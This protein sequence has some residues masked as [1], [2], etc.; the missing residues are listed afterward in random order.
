[1]R[2]EFTLWTALLSYVAPALGGNLLVGYYPTWKHGNI[3]TM[4]L[5]NYT[6]INIAFAIPNE[7][8]ALKF[9]GDAFM[10]K[11]VPKLQGGGSKVL[12]SVGGW[13]G[14]ANFSTIVKD[15]ALSGTLTKN[16]IDMMKKYKLDG[17]DID[18]EF[19]GRKGS[20]C[21]TVDEQ[22]DATNFLKY[23][24]DLRAKMDEALGKGKLITLALR[25]QPFDGPGGKDVSGFAKVVDFANLMQY[26]LNGAWGETSG[27]LAPLNFEKG[28]GTQQ[29]FATA[30]EEWTKAGWP[31]KQ[32]TGGAAFYGYSATAT[33]DM[34]KSNPPSQYAKMAKE[35]PKGDQDD[36]MVTEPCSSAA[37]TYTGIWVYK[38]LRKQGVLSSPDTAE[39][40]WVRTFDNK[41]MT[42][43]LFNPQTKTFISYDDPQSLAAKVKFAESKGL[44]GMMVWSIER[45]Y[46]GELLS[47][48][49]KFSSK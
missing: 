34:L 45:D 1:M 32:L 11:V 24:T 49:K 17:I 19:P 23:L 41:T 48:L 46:N 20:D 40:P 33:E 6:H 36:E 18:W 37:A 15:T 38:N 3:S 26:D 10:D 44:G 7:Q 8:G 12:V 5:S 27:P 9:E 21:N 16:I 22:N 4:D 35:R 25:V 39:A 31:A 28:K 47:E 43:W 2:F 14:S 42:P 13:S 29:S 30:I